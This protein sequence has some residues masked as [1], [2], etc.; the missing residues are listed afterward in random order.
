MLNFA[1]LVHLRPT[2]FRFDFT[3]LVAI[4]TLCTDP[5]LSYRNV[6]GDCWNGKVSRKRLPGARLS[7]L[8]PGDEYALS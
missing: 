5:F 4:F 8:D 2:W 3:G 1:L 6:V 7:T